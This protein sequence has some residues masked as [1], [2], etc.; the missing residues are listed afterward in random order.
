MLCRSCRRRITVR[1]LLHRAF[2]S[3]WATFHEVWHFLALD[4]FHLREV[5]H[6]HVVQFF[7]QLENATEDVH[8]MTKRNCRVTT[9]SQR[10][11]I[12]LLNLNLSPVKGGRVELPQVT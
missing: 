4:E 7:G 12:S 5:E 10:L 2:S 1:I 6:Q 9:S 3:S 8:P 11:Q